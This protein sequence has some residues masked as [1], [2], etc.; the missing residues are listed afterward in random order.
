MKVMARST[1]NCDADGKRNSGTA[2]R[3]AVRQRIDGCRRT[4]QRISVSGLRAVLRLGRN[5]HEVAPLHC[6]D[7]LQLAGGITN[8][9]F[10]ILR[11]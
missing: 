4:D 6:V 3:A 9:A 7:E 1:C 10:V 8:E 11:K 2:L 5:S